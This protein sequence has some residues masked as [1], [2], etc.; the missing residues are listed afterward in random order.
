MKVKIFEL[1]TCNEMQEQF[2]LLMEKIAN[3]QHKCTD[4][5][6]Q[7]W[8]DNQDVCMILNISQRTLQTYRS[9]GKIGYSQING[10]IYYKGSDVEK[11]LKQ[12]NSHT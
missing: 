2:R 11:L 9:T 6:L 5:K 7:R 8:L 10:K 1:Q 12:T 3:L 4:K